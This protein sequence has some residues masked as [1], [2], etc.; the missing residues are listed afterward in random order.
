MR[1]LGKALLAFALLHSIFQGQICL[2]LQVFLD[3]LLLHFFT[4]QTLN[5]RSPRFPPAILESCFPGERHMSSDCDSER[6]RE[7]G[8][9][10]CRPLGVPQ[11][12]ERHAACPARLCPRHPVQVGRWTPHRETS[13]VLRPSQVWASVGGDRTLV[14]GQRGKHL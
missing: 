1:S 3:F 14:R 4:G 12:W 7:G 9:C 6:A 13:E 5:P 11:T 8:L 10:R 2:L